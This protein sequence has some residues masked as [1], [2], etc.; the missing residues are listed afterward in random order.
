MAFKKGQSGNPRGKK[1]GTPNKLTAQGRALF[2]L[3][4]ARREAEA[5]AA[6]PVAEA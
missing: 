1:K 2:K 4:L 3:M 5:A 6:A